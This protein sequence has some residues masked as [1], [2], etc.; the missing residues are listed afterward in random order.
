MRKL[1]CDAQDDVEASEYKEL[2]KKHIRQ[3]N[4][5]KSFI[6]TAKSMV[7]PYKNFRKNH[8]DFNP[9]LYPLQF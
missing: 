7:K 4:E 6:K 1:I 2:L 8:V 3:K 5:Q 9:G